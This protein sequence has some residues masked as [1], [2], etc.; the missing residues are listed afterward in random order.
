MAS[1]AEAEVSAAAALSLLLV[2]VPD[3]P[4]APSVVVAVTE[5]GAGRHGDIVVA[6]PSSPPFVIAL[7]GAPVDGTARLRTLP[8]APP[9]MA[10]STAVDGVLVTVDDV[11]D[12]LPPPASAPP[13]K[14]AAK[15]PKTTS[16]AT[17]ALPVASS[18]GL[19][20]LVPDAVAAGPTVATLH[21]AGVVFSGHAIVVDGTADRLVAL[22]VDVPPDSQ[23]G[24]PDASGPVFVEAPATAGRCGPA[25]RQALQRSTSLR[26]LD[27]VCARG[28]H[29]VPATGTR[30]DA[31]ID[32][33]RP[34]HGVVVRRRSSAMGQAGASALGDVD[35]AARQ[36]YSQQRS[37]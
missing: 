5:D 14:K 23:I 12:W 33:D 15:P 28:L 19:R 34:A 2:F 24:V 6:G 30:L 8:I 26:G 3:D 7:D 32:R 4:R 25:P 29:V 22:S 20:L 31:V 17:S 21:G 36:R 16:P 37:R 9:G 13:S 11:G 18:R 10:L 35:N 1:S 27:A